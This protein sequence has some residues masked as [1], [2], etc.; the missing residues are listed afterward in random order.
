MF[1]SLY[2]LLL[3]GCPADVRADCAMEMEAIARWLADA[4]PKHKR[5]RQGRA[6]VD[7]IVFMVTVR[8]DERLRQRGRRPRVWKLK[9]N[10]KAA[11]RHLIA[12]PGFSAAIVVML[13]L[14]IGASTA[15]F[16]VV[17]GVLLKPLPFAEP[18]R[19]VEIYQAIPARQISQSSL[20][21]ANTWDI[22]D[23]NQAFSEMGSLHSASFSLTGDGSVPE[24]LSGATVSAGFL[25]A[26]GVT[27]LV[28]R[29]F[30][31]G[32][33][34]TG[35]VR[36]RVILS[37]RLWTRRFG[38]DRTIVGRSIT[39]DGRGYEVIGV[40]PRGPV[41]LANNDVFVPFLRRPNAD[42]GSWEFA[43]IGR[44]K[45]GVTYEAGVAD[46]KRVA[47]QLE[48]HP[49]NKGWDIV[50][51]RSDTWVASDDLR[52]MLWVMLWAVLLLLVIASVNVANLLLVRASARAR[53][54]AVRTALG[55]T[56]GDL[57]REGLTESMLLSAFGMVMGVAVAYGMLKV[58]KAA[59]PGGIPRLEEV[60]LNGWVLAFTV[61]V[62]AVVGIATGLVPALQTPFGNIVTALRPGQRGSIGDRRHDR[63]RSAFVIIEVALSVLLLIGAGLLVRSLANV[64]TTD[65]G[66]ATERR[67]TA[68]V[69]IP[70]GYPEGRRTE[71][72]T[73]I[74]ADVGRLPEVVSVGAVSGVPLSGGST[75]MGFDAADKLVGDSAPWA[76]WRLITKDYFTTMGLNVLEG[77]AFTEQ[78]VIE[79]PW[80]VII[81]QRLARQM[82]PGTSAVGK[83]AILWKG[84]NELKAEVIGVVSDMRERGLESDPTLAVYI[85]A[86]GAL[87]GTT[88]RLV[89]QTRGEPM[90]AAGSLRA[91][92][93]A[94]DP[95]L[96]IS[97]IRSLDELVARSVA[98]RRFT[99]FLLVTFAGLALLLAL[100]GVAGVLAFSMARRTG[101]MG[102][103][104]ALGAR[105]SELVRLAM[106]Q[107]LTPVAIGLVV[108]VGG[109]Y[110][111]SKL[112]ANLLF[113]VT[114]RDPLTFTVT[115]G[116]LVVAA[117]LACYLP[118][119]KAMSVDPS[120]A[121]RME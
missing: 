20:S 119:R 63:T 70:R 42:R 34:N 11:W 88:L 89:I 3:R 27:P 48:H 77:R 28:G 116:A 112:L 60:A 83:T 13:A 82:W 49:D 65:R 17:Y 108:G 31:T 33:D 18:D 45:P 64:L 94:I 79:K 39:L 58:F 91:A 107:G 10:T 75:G 98:T 35:A 21:E 62:A 67:L 110:W 40:L 120:Q 29:V 43:M 109:A 68:T 86:Y 96:P 8:R 71:I 4:G 52:R 44:L 72:A 74:L 99:M 1:T 37:E 69:T 50:A 92:V 6:L 114:A 54:R 16:S 26:L 7:L 105:H 66:F 61:A 9:Q 117:A 115:V 5:W 23:L 56:R 90:A 103:R 57:L 47:K 53:D 41:W 32:E 100:A 87:G 101:E 76:S 38:A 113:G 102:I 22:K 2:R 30:E 19:I 106:R 104:L 118:A 36:E 46:L 59:D 25:R 81:S 121:L 55:A 24:R 80:R 78:D 12:R 84:Q 95:S 111:L 15:I 93:G 85:P 14:G 97:A 73:R 51:Q